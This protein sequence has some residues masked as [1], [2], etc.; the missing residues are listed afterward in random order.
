MNTFTTVDTDYIRSS[1][2][3]ESVLVSNPKSD[4]MFYVYNYEGYSFRVFDSILNLIQFFQNQIES[5]LH[6]QNE[7]EL[8]SFFSHV[9]LN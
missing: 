4:K 7:K 1:R 2:T 5:T 9:V 6:F 3:I 8:D